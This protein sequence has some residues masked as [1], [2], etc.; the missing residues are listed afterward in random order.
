MFLAKYGLH[1]LLPGKVV[2]VICLFFL[3][4]F[5]VKVLVDFIAS[6]KENLQMPQLPISKAGY[7]VQLIG[8]PPTDPSLCVLDTVVEVRSP[9]GEVVCCWATLDSESSHLLIGSMKWSLPKCLTYIAR[10]SG[11][12]VLMEEDGSKWRVT[13][14]SEKTE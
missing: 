2:G 12:R 14:I 8:D 10:G 5:L 7:I 9:D 13:E 6:R 1:N 11:C 4:F 3:A